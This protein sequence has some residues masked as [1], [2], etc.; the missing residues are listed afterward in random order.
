MPVEASGS[1]SLKYLSIFGQCGDCFGLCLSLQLPFFPPYEVLQ[2]WVPETPL[3]GFPD[4]TV[5]KNLPA[6]GG[7]TRDVDLIPEAGRSP[8]EGNVNPLQHSCLENSMD[9]G[10]WRAT[11]RGA[12]ES[13]TRARTGMTPPQCHGF[14][15][16][17]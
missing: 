11:V 17:V 2:F 4:G 12:T 6:N 3:P 14:S 7:D 10:A 5:V 1:K 16:S 9:R 15:L 8:V 13:W